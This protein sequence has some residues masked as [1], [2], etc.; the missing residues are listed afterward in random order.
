MMA[1]PSGVIAVCQTLPP[2]LSTCLSSCLTYDV[3]AIIS[4]PFKGE[5]TEA[6]RS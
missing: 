3:D 4:L 5:E 2:A 6:Q 1:G